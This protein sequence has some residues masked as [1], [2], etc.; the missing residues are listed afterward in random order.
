MLAGLVIACWEVQRL[1]ESLQK[2]LREGWFLPPTEFYSS[3]L[4]F[5]TGSDINFDLIKEHLNGRDFRLRA[6]QEPLRPN[7]YSFLDPAACEGLTGQKPDPA[8][9]AASRGCF[10]VRSGEKDLAVISYDEKFKVLQIW[11]GPQFTPSPSVSVAPALMAQFY[12]GQPIFKEPTSLPSVP[13]ECLEAVTAIEDPDFL[14]HKGVS[15]VGILRAFYRNLLAGH[16]AQGGSTITQQL[17]KNYFLSPKKTLRRKVTEQ[18]LSVLLEAHTSKDTILEQ[19]LNVIF[20]GLAGPYQIRGFASASRYYFGKTISQLNLAECGLLAAM[21][22]SPGRYNP[23]EHP[24]HAMK[25]RELV[26]RKM[27]TLDL[28]SKQELQDALIYPLPK[29]SE[30]E[31]QSPA[32]YFLQAA[33]R[34]LDQLE[35]PPDKGLRVITAFN[36][37]DQEAANQAVKERVKD[38]ESKSKKKK[39]GP[40]QIALITVELPSRHVTALVG[41]RNYQETQFNRIVDG[42]RQVGST[43]KPFVYLTAMD[44]LNPLSERVDEPFEFKANHQRWAPKNY[45]GKFRGPIP[46]FFGLAESLNIPAA[47][48]GLEIGIKNVAATLMQAGVERE[49]PVNPSLALGAFE[50]S[51][52]ELA[53]AFSTLANFGK[54]Q[55]IHSIER[56][57]TLDGETLW[58]EM[59]LPVEQTLNPAHAAEVIGM[60]KTTPLVGTA[61]ALKGFNLPQVVAAKTGTTNDLKDAWFVGFTPQQLTI[62]WVGFDD[63]QPVGTGAQMALPVWGKFHSRIASRLPTDDFQWPPEVELR[64]IKLSELSV[65]YPALA[66]IA[67]HV[68]AVELVFEKSH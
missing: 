42:F 22:N 8:G 27:Q 52:W 53:Q 50:L 34:E 5:V 33:Q 39:T 15:F 7:D 45:D 46:L 60:M 48:T 68:P 6:P 49:V 44:K 41:G 18:V 62:V 56:V 9:A 55:V 38:Y 31:A 26:L 28:I 37:D 63:N 67:G 61:Q 2:R 64:N 16:W 23:F 4:H 35:L 3:G 59:K 19:Y 1:D 21:V 14:H 66:K 13:L 57:E 10:A 43:M 17:V 11:S 20:M 25:R 36:S 65:T 47:K 24:D 32:P 12:E 54:H 58:D 40:L 30:L 29:R 51:P